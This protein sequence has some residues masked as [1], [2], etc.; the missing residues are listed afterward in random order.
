MER[1]LL[2]HDKLNLRISPCFLLYSVKIVKSNEKAPLTGK[3][4]K[5]DELHGC[6]F[7]N[8]EAGG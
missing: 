4:M 1:L 2:K 7:E 8:W 6:H 5:A 3:G